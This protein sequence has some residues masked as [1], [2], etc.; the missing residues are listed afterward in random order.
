MI[1]TRPGS[2]TCWEQAIFP[3]HFNNKQSVKEDKI[4]IE[5]LVKEHVR[6]LKK[7]EGEYQKIPNEIFCSMNHKKSCQRVFP[8]KVEKILDFT[9]IPL[10]SLNI[11]KMEPKAQ[12][13]M[14]MSQN[15]LTKCKVDLITE[16][17]TNNGIELPRI[18]GISKLSTDETYD[19]VFLDPVLQSGRLDSKLLRQ[20]D[21]SK[22][23]S[24]YFSPNKL[25][26]WISLIESEELIKNY[27]MLPTNDLTMGFHMVKCLIS[28]YIR[29]K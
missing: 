25:T 12:L 20:L 10:E 21:E 24:K 11:L 26:I 6:L 7:E 16:I 28:Q 27:K 17:A 18:D 14:F 9:T 4:E 19:L 3:L 22:L 13:T 8:E 23:S 29:N 15:D 2:D 1:N 5:F